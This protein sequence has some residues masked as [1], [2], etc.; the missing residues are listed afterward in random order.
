[1]STLATSTT[2]VSEPAHK[3]ITQFSTIS[4]NISVMNYKEIIIN[5][6]KSLIILCSRIDS[7]ENLS[8]LIHT[9]KFSGKEYNYV[10][11]STFSDCPDF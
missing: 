5:S 9:F 2:S 1:M 6:I 7:Y 10:S 8:Y 3:V 11:T 4:D